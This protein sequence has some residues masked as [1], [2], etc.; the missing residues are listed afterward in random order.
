MYFKRIEL[1]G[2]KSFADPVSIEFHEGITCIVGPNGSGKSNI[3]DAIRWVLGE[4]SPKMLRGGKMEEVIFAG[5][6]SRK[7]RGMAEVTLVIDN[8]TGVLPIDYAEVAIT[9][10]MYR[11]GESAYSINNNPCRLRDIREL[12]MDTGIGVDGYSLI[13]QGKISEIVSN[14]PESRREIFE[15]AAGIVKY[16]SKKAEAERKLESSQ[17]NLDRV[18][19]IVGEIESRIDSLKE[20]SEKASEYMVL[21]DK[22]KEIEIN[23]TLKNIES[24]ELKNESL[25]DDLTELNI[26]IEN[27]KEKK[28]TVDAELSESRMNNEQLEIQGLETRD[29]LL[30]KV[31]EINSLVNQSQ[32]SDEKLSTMEKDAERL[33]EEILNLD[34]KTDKE[35]VNRKELEQKY[36]KLKEE[37][38]KYKDELHNKTQSYEMLSSE[39]TTQEAVAEEQK[40]RIYELHSIMSSKKAESNSLLSLLNTLK[41]RQE[42][43]N[44]E[45]ETTF[46]SNKGMRQ[47]F[48]KVQSENRAAL[49]HLKQIK[50]N[51]QVTKIQYEEDLQREKTL[52]QKL[53]DLRISMG[54]LTTRQKMMEE[55]EQAYDGY[56]HGVRFIMRSKELT[57]IHGVITD[58]IEVPL[59]YET[60]IETA[61]G[62]AMQN[63]VCED[64]KSAQAAV[65]ALKRNRAGRLTFLPLSSIRAGNH[66]RD[67]R[68]NNA[69]GFKGVA[70]DCIG[71]DPKYKKIME[72]LLGRV[73]LVE[74]LEHA[75][76]LSKSISGGFRFVT[77]EGEVLNASG[78]ITGGVY[79]NNT[80]NLLERK[81]EIV[82][83]KDALSKM[84]QEK[85]QGDRA[86]EELHARIN[87][88]K[89]A[90]ETQEKE[91]RETEMVSMRTEN[92]LKH[93]S[94]Q[95]TEAESSENRWIRELEHIT[96]EEQSARSMIEELSMVITSAEQEKSALEDSVEEQTE[97]FRDKKQ[98]LQKMQEDI[99]K[100][101]I[102]VNTLKNECNGFVQMDQKIEDYLQELTKEKEAK[103]AAIHSIEERKALLQQGGGD[104]KS[105]VSSKEKEKLELEQ[106]LVNLQEEKKRLV[107]SLEEAE[108]IKAS[109]DEKL[110]QEQTNKHDLELK[111]AKNETQVNSF[112]D[113]LWEDFEISYIQAMEFS[114]KEFIMNTAVKESREIKSRMKVLG[115]VNLGSIKEYETVKER[116]EFLTEQRSDLLQAID[117]LKQIISD[118]DKTIR[119]N[120]KDSFDKIVANFEKAFQELFGGGT[121]ELRLEDET[122]PLECGIEIVAQPPGKKLQNINLMSG[123][124]KTMTA[125]ALM[126]AVL[127]AKPTPF[128]ILDEVEAAL[129][130]ANIDRFAQYLRNFHEIQF[131][132]V[133]HQKA[134]MEFADV[135]YGVTMP[136]QGVSKVISLRFGDRFEL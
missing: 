108:K 32:L 7:S 104:L 89:A 130:E 67:D 22:Y 64:E 128:C 110:L 97:K 134:T 109:I 105:A 63:I 115:E 72:Y 60:A 50:E 100:L 6:A 123:G 117:A 25:K 76:A 112:K 53:A 57:G 84:E 37:W 8:S 78:A 56:N 4:Q 39:V 46:L 93:V 99:T 36:D 20:E 107:Q 129:D 5:T 92:E 45:K 126:F 9:R 90:L 41:S 87:Q 10:R 83:L 31:E 17:N 125:I 28:K 86:L 68:L 49:D 12:I 69:T 102:E 29:L 118:M 58:L 88:S 96:N 47:T 95:L 27:D 116:Y 113:K 33:K 59:G 18:N 40:N 77:L 136:E 15:E 124:E 127:R 70:V 80:A 132:L 1:H 94:L 133:T 54:Q 3:S 61:L 114:K 82:K 74:K 44:T 43:L 111:L 48:E 131:A 103:E 75:V 122:R 81:T 62:S 13:G 91:Y 35:M 51:L 42:Q 73:I 106:M 66:A 38:Q 65:S 2:F 85:T 121:A 52:G 79:R 135:L 120:F 14:K 119:N 30:K 34:K 19:D 101:H 26:Q 21:R 71:F 11:S 24:I 98:E 23:I 55:M 16:R